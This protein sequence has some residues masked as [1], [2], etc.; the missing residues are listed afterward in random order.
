MYPVSV[1][2]SFQNVFGVSPAIVVRAP[3]RINL[4]GEH[5][6][7]NEGFVMPAAIDK[8][9]WFAVSLRADQAIH[10]HALDFQESWTSHLSHLTVSGKGWPDYLLGPFSELLKDGHVLQGANVVFGGDIPTGAGLS[11]SAAVESGMLFAINELHHLGLSRPILARLAQRAEN[12][13]VGM[14]CGIMDM[15]A[16]LMGKAGH[17]IQLD[18]RDLSF[19]HFPLELSSHSLLLCDSGVKHALIDSEFNTRRQECETGVAVLKSVFP[20]VSSLRDVTFAMLE[21][22][23]G[24]LSPVVYKRCRYVLEE[25]A[26]VLAVIEA[27]NTGNL[28]EVGLL[29][30]QT[31]VGL[32][33]AYE[34]SCDEIDFLVA[35]ALLHPGVLG[36][37][38]MGGGFGGCTINLVPTAA[39]HDFCQSM[40]LEYQASFARKLACYPVSLTNGVELVKDWAR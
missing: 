39:I 15:F 33:D 18:C 11:S 26:R 7:Y 13:F 2:Q 25:N 28:K 40:E 34:V 8:A 32:R 14:K 6:D 23:Q 10:L 21:Q 29:M 24:Q 1:V 37:R 5:T 3:G 31:H 16:S 12:N 22:A 4:I 17:V 27:L 35:K 20:A 19:A 36:S 9:I 38:M 30:R